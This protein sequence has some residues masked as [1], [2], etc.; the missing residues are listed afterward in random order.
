MKLWGVA[1][2][3]TAIAPLLFLDCLTGLGDIGKI[4]LLGVLFL[5]SLPWN[6]GAFVVI[7]AI[8]NLWPEDFGSFYQFVWQITA[9]HQGRA[10][11]LEWSAIWYSFILGTFLNT[12][13]AFWLSTRH[14]RSRPPAST[15]TASD[16]T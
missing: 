6:I 14:N 1:I 11:S 4:V 10:P 7:V 8:Y 5:I 13:L 2:G 9:C 15:G 3:L 12:Q 16:G